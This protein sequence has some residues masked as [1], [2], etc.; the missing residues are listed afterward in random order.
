[1]FT[2]KRNSWALMAVLVLLSML[3]VQ[4]AP[5]AT[6]APEKPAEATA[7]AEE[8]PFKVGLISPGPVNDKGW[9]QLAYDSLLKIEKDLGAEISY[10]EVAESPAEF[11]KALTDYASQGYQFVIAHGFQF[12]DAVEKVAPQFPD[13]VFVTSGGE[14]YGPNYGPIVMALWEPLY[15]VGVI[16]G[17]LSKTGK[18]AYIGGM[19]IPAISGPYEGM[20]QGFETVEGNTFSI[21][22]INSWEDVGAAKEAALA[23]AAEGADFIVANANIAGT[24]VFQVCNEKKIWTAGLNADQTAEAPD[25]VLGNGVIDYPASFVTIA[26]SVKDGTFVGNRPIVLTLKDEDAVY[27]KLNPKTEN[28]ITPEI[29]AKV[30]EA[31]AK[32]KSG[33]ILVDGDYT[34]K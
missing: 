8:K 15:L 26:K 23:A 4:C 32:I 14:K 30:D 19:E 3:L 31:A 21:T 1:M 7:P 17:N 13:T 6:P 25:Y 34:R 9:N 33:E 5:A 18:G 27:L 12:Q 2:V 16:A 29:Q 28:L 11:E 10:V 20:K 24:G 22:Y